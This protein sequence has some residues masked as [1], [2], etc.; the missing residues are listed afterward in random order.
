MMHAQSD[1]Y[2]QKRTSEY[3]DS[4]SSSDSIESSQSVSH[5]SLCGSSLSFFFLRIY[6]LQDESKSFVGANKHPVQ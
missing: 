1:E 6:A 4:S 3:S 5:I 2:K